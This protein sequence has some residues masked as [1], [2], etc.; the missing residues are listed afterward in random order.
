MNY[1]NNLSD[2]DKKTQS[3]DSIFSGSTGPSATF[4]SSS[5]STPQSVHMSADLI[6]NAKSQ[7]DNLCGA[8]Q[9]LNS[10]P[11]TDL[12]SLIGSALTVDITGN[13]LDANCKQISSTIMAIESK[14][15]SEQVVSSQYIDL[16]PIC[17]STALGDCLYGWPNK[18]AWLGDLGYSYN[19]IH[20][21]LRIGLEGWSIETSSHDPIFGQPYFK[22]V[23]NHCNIFPDWER[24]YYV[25]N[26][27]H[28]SFKPFNIKDGMKYYT[29]EEGRY[30]IAGIGDKVEWILIDIPHENLLNDSGFSYIVFNWAIKNLVCE[31]CWD[32]AHPLGYY[33][34]TD[35]MHDLEQFHSKSNLPI[36]STP[37]IQLESKRIQMQVET[38][39]QKDYGDC[40]RGADAYIKCKRGDH[41]KL[42]ISI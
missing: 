22:D 38:L 26:C 11:D 3:K 10:I 14:I 35:I 34:V 39:F 41:W 27:E 4:D 15:S 28:G 8:G 6:R 1:Q 24:Q 7:I 16:S 17:T 19:E 2:I 13:I 29:G 9:F 32:N 12:E 30:V 37:M 23:Q 21:K 18:P 5:G 20:E 25:R 33:V 36:S 42:L 40:F 31:S